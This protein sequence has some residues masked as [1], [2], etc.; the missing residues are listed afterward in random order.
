[1]L[2]TPPFLKAATFGTVRVGWLIERLEKGFVRF[3]N[4]LL[5]LARD[6]SANRGQG[7]QV[8]SDANKPPTSY[9]DLKVVIPEK[10]TAFA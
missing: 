7:F 4:L 2:A 9:H 1:M 6:A 10:F 3:E 5:A 8:Q